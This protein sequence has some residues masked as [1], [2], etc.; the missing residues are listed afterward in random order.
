MSQASPEISVPSVMARNAGIFWVRKLTSNC[1]AM[2]V[3]GPA[4]SNNSVLALG[5]M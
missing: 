5:S 3:S 2:T 1:N 4:T